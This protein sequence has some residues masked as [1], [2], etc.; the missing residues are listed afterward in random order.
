MRLGFLALACML[1]TGARGGCHHTSSNMTWA[2]GTTTVQGDEFITVEPYLPEETEWLDTGDLLITYNF[3]GY[4]C[5]EMDIES[6]DLSVSDSFGYPI[7]DVFDAPCSLLNELYLVNMPYD[8]YYVTAIARDGWG[9][10][11]VWYDGS[12][13]H[14]DAFTWMDVNLL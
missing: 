12:V 2:S 8:R 9:D 7:V 11:I 14:A 13:F 3:S 4:D 5:W 6:V 1:L 10:E